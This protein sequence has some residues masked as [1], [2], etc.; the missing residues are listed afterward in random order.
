MRRTQTKVRRDDPTVCVEIVGSAINGS[1][2]ASAQSVAVTD[3]RA[4]VM[5]SALLVLGGMQ[6]GAEWITS[7][8]VP[9]AL[10]SKVSWPSMSA[11]VSTTCPP[12]ALAIRLQQS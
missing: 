3:S 8:A 1:H 10:A 6:P 2:N 5:I 4:V 7:A 12:V 11:R 9:R